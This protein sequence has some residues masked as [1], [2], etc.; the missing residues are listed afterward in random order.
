MKTNLILFASVAIVS[1][2]IAIA[3]TN[4]PAN[5]WKPAPSNQAGREYPQFNSEGRLKFRINSPKAQSVGVSFRESSAFTRGEDGAWY[6]YTRP[7][8]EGF[9]YY[10]INIDGAD[11]P[12]V[13][14]GHG[15]T[16]GVLRRR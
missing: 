14:F 3:Q 11:V 2:R 13:R 6:G 9:H 1:G 4:E 12:V 7:L 10:T 16:S 8:D 15:D 5:D